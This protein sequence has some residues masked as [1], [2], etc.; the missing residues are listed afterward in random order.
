MVLQGNRI[1]LRKFKKEDAEEYFKISNETGVHKYLPYASPQ[2]L[3]ESKELME[4]YI[5]YD[6]I[7]DFYFVIEE[8]STHRMIGSLTSY[9]T[10]SIALNVSSFIGKDFR[11]NGFGLEALNLFIDYLSKNTNYKSL[12][13]TIHDGNE[14]SLKVMQKI[15]AKKFQI[16]TLDNTSSYEYQIKSAN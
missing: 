5:T 6:F 7:N 16:N 14:A 4:N 13:F 3:A 8:I 12:V 1:L 11:K 10:T 15:G 2:D 9:R